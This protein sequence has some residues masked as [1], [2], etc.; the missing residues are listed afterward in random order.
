MEIRCGWAT[1]YGGVKYDVSVH[2]ADLTR[3]L[4]AAGVSAQ[5]HS[6]VTAEEAW[7]I[8]DAEARWLAEHASAR[9]LRGTGG[10]TAA[11]SAAERATGAVRDRIDALK[12]LRKRLGLEGQNGD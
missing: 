7:A 8:M 11:D 10:V 3:I 6:E 2:E 4:T 1:E 5:R 12:K 9:Y